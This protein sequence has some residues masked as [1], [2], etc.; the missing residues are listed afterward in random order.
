MKLFGSVLLCIVLLLNLSATPTNQAQ[1][2]LDPIPK[3]T[4]APYFEFPTETWLIERND[5]IG[6]FL[7]WCFIPVDGQ[8]GDKLTWNFTWSQK[9][10][11]LYDEQGELTAI[12]ENPIKKL[13]EGKIQ[14]VYNE[15]KTLSGF[16]RVDVTKLQFDAEKLDQYPVSIDLKDLGVFR[17]TPRVTVDI[18]LKNGWFLVELNEWKLGTR[19]TIGFGS[20]IVYNGGTNTITLTGG[21]LGTEI[22]FWDLWNASDVNG[23]NVAHNNNN[24]DIQFEFECRIIIGDGSTPTWF[25]DEEVQVLFEDPLS[26]NDQDIITV[27]SNANFRLGRLQNALLHSTSRGCHII[28]NDNNYGNILDSGGNIEIYSCAISR[29]QNQLHI[30]YTFRIWNTI[31]YY[32]D[33]RDF[34]GDAFNVIYTGRQAGYFAVPGVGATYDRITVLYA[35]NI[36][37]V[38]TADATVDNLY[39]RHC[40]NVVRFFTAGRTLTLIDP[41]VD[42][43]SINFGGQDSEVIRQYTFNAQIVD[44]LGT[45]IYDANVTLFNSDGSKAF[46][47][48]TAIDGSITEQTVSR[49]F[50]NITGGNVLYDYGPFELNV[51]YRDFMVNSISNITL[52]DPIDWTVSLSVEPDQRISSGLLAVIILV[53]LIGVL[54]WGSK[55]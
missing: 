8:S 46:T 21:G 31:L 10:L 3:D 28:F 2:N 36:L 51:T 23:W 11:E 9:D 38:W 50:Y 16:D 25:A 5:Y 7:E 15:L 41:D 54:L 32:T 24:T 48:S 47:V 33:L 27:T 49:G 6:Q 55:R 30:R 52:E 12:Y 26:A 14:E 19:I 35:G 53:P 44:N 45:G 1:I 42:L 40:S 29:I 4:P 18:T 22:D 43:W 37:H 17:K 39:A 20:T 13:G 34:D